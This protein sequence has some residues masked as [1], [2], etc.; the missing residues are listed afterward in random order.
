MATILD[1]IVEY[2]RQFVESTKRRVPLA[3]LKSRVL[4][5][6]APPL[7][8][9][10][11]HR[12]DD[13]QVNVIAEVKKKSP[14]KGIIRE[15][16]DP[17]RIAIDYAEHGAAAISV[18]T[19]EEFFAGS[20]DYLRQ[21]RAEFDDEQIPLLRKDFT[22]DEYQIFEARDAGAAAILLITS[23][24]DKYQLVDY[25]EL[26]NELGMDALTEVHLEAEADRAAELGARII[27]INNRDLHTFDVDLKHTQKIMRLLGGPLRGYIFVAESGI[28][29]YEHVQ[30]LSSFGVDAILV[31][32]TLMRQPKPGLALQKLLGTDEESIEARAEDEERT[33]RIGEGG[34]Q[35]GGMAE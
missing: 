35:R 23:I 4:D 8:A 6:P 18:L 16:F 29:T 20:L 34:M 17:I 19:D 21:I 3:E 31:G 15:D 14:S 13:E 26:A 33:R 27:G 10:A 1:Q 28:Q 5:M 12:G 25:R 30:Q 7:F 32:E 24:L 2:K 9:P 22:I 11:I